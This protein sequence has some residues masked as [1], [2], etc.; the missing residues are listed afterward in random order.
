MRGSMA[1]RLLVLTAI[2]AL[3]ASARPLS[4]E[5][6]A[7]AEEEIVPIMGKSWVDSPVLSRG[8]DDNAERERCAAA[9]ATS[10]S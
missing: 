4:R 7:E 8:R 5:D 1:L 6:G 2:L 3:A 10:S 9:P